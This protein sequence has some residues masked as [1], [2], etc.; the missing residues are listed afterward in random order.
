[1]T[2]P[3]HVDVELMQ[4]AQGEEQGRQTWPPPLLLLLL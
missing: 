1:L 3:V 2:Q 4:S